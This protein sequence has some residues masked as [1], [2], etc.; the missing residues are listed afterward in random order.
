MWQNIWDIDWRIRWIAST[1]TSIGKNG[2]RIEEKNRAQC[3]NS[4][5]IK[6]F[7]IAMQHNRSL[8]KYLLEALRC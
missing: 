8:N 4:Q 5:Q 6:I 2:K 1:K 3:T 7:F